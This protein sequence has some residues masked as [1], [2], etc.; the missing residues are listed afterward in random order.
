V[1]LDFRHDPSRRGDVEIATAPILGSVLGEQNRYGALKGRTPGG[2]PV[3]FARVPTDDRD[4]RMT[5]YV[6]EGCF[7]DDP[8]DTFGTGAVVEVPA[9]QRLMQFVCRNGFEH[10]AVMNASRSAEVLAES[11]EQYLG[12]RV[13]HHQG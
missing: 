3:T 7:T 13:Y 12:W 10:H 11:F 6:G 8:L 1:V 2:R 5:S 9:L 4:G